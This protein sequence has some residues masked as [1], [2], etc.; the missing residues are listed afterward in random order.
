[1]LHLGIGMVRAGAPGGGSVPFRPEAQTVIAAMTTPPTEQR[2]GEINALVA[3]LQDAAV[4]NRIGVLYVFAAHDQQAAL[5]NWKDPAGTPALATGSPPFTVDRGFVGDNTAAHIDTQVAWNAVPGLTQDDA[6]MGV[7]AS[8]SVGSATVA[9]QVT[10]ANATISRNAG[11]FATRLHNA[12]AGNGGMIG[13]TPLH[14]CM[15]RA[16]STGYDRYVDGA[17]DTT[18]TVASE[19]PSTANLTGLRSN[20]AFA[21][22]NVSLRAMHAGASLSAG[23]AAAMAGAIAAYMAAV[24]ANA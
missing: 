24:G 9:G 17:F 14:L 20:T 16:A 19:A 8:I 2:Q 13:T 22:S 21:P 11:A 5:I 7:Y 23:Q 18:H 12:A 15:S 6:H 1:M 4:W 3:A 10:G